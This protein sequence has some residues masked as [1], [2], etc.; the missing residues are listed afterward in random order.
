MSLDHMTTIPG[1][2]GPADIGAH[3][4]HRVVAE[5]KVPNAGFFLS[6]LGKPTAFRR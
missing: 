1:L 6:L 3:A 5:G 4:W 2:R